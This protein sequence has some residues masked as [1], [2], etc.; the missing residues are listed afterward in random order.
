MKLQTEGLQ[1]FVGGQIEVQNDR[2]D[3]LYRGEISRIEVTERSPVAGIKRDNY[4]DL[5]IKLKWIAKMEDGVWEAS[6]RLDYFASL[7][8]YN[9]SDIGEGRLLLHASIV[10]ET[11]TLFP[12]G[13]SAL[14]P[15]EVK[16]LKLEA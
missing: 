4:G 5:S 13:G 3:Y 12:Q 14:D 15:S 9:A 2:E 1:R 11:T 16:G 7:L 6:N 8:V 10:G